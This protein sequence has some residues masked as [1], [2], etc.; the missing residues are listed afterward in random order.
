MMDTLS[1]D[2]IVISYIRQPAEHADIMRK[3][4]RRLAAGDKRPRFDGWYLLFGILAGAGLY[5]F[6]YCY[7]GLVLI[8]MFGMSPLVGTGDILLICFLPCL[9]A[10][11]LVIVYFRYA[12]SV[13]LTTAS[14]RIRADVPVTA[15]ITRHGVTWDSPGSCLQLDWHSVSD[16]AD[17]DGRIEFDVESSVFYIPGH[18]FRTQREQAAV[19]ERILSFWVPREVANS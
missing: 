17:R 15:T 19:L 12:S 18:A 5:F 7:R 1:D 2:R 3:A 6:F 13:R 9:L 14:E 4:G 10:Y 11:L 8:P 16:I